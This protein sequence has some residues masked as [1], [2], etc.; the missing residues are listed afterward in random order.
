MCS[1][2]KTRKMS[3]GLL[4]NWNLK[5]VQFSFILPSRQRLTDSPSHLNQCLK[6]QT[7]FKV[8]ENAVIL[9]WPYS[10]SLLSWVNRYGFLVSIKYNIS[11]KSQ[12]KPGKL[13]FDMLSSPIQIIQ[14]TGTKKNCEQKYRL[15]L[16][17]LLQRNSHFSD[18]FRDVFPERSHWNESAL[19]H[20]RSFW[21]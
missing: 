21:I 7:S 6:D 13:I 3:S 19:G 1:S 16:N 5:S 4:S 10:S 15:K 8:Q 12:S 18:D 17:R 14:L 11:L 20:F 9:I 2:Y